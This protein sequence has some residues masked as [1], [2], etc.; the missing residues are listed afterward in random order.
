MDSYFLG[1]DI[2]GTASRFV[3]CDQAGTIVQ[4]GAAAGATGHTF[5]AESRATL[6]KSIAAIAAQITKPVDAA[7]FGL[8][9]Y[10]P[11]ARIDIEDMLIAALKLA[12][13]K[14]FISD[15][16]ELAYRSLF[17]LG[18]GH[19]VSAGTGSIAVHLDSEGRLFRIGGRG[20]LIDD[21]G[22]GGWIG[23]AAV[24]ALYRRLDEEGAPGD[25]RLLADALYAAVG[26]DDWSDMRAYIYAGDRGRIGAL[27]RSVADAAEAGDACAN[28]L[29]RE[30]GAELA[31]LGNILIARN[32]NHPVAFVG[33]VLK[34]HPVIAETIRQRLAGEARF[35]VLDQAEGAAR[36]A[37]SFFH[38]ASSGP[39]A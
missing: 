35:P 25:M 9:G 23:L 6:E 10:G 1:G 33:G 28:G 8:T 2:G 14:I 37:L 19:L 4:R 13:A 22:S 20:I 30:A 27:A 21:A 32:G 7:V 24:R 5:N 3:L 38:P 34:L 15:D 18:E 36:L 29:L 26:S 17:A 11:R 39:S 12:R 16:I 31:R